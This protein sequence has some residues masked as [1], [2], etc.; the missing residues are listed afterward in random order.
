MT[1]STTKS[2]PIQEAAAL[3]GISESTLRR[4]LRAG[5]V[6]ARQIDTPQGFKWMV[7][8][9]VEDDLD[10]NPAHHSRDENHFYSNELAIAVEELRARVAS[11][12]DQ[13]SVKDRQI[14]AREREVGE[15]H[16]LLAQTALVAAEKRSWWRFWK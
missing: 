9:E 5:Q 8:I 16:R 2:V 4:R 15:L 10:S 3:L 6:N 14:E 1:K 12:Q 7:D 11:L 13:L